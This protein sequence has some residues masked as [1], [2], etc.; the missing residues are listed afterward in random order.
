[1]SNWDKTQPNGREPIS[2]G[3]LRIREIKDALETAFG[4]EHDFPTTSY[5]AF[6]YGNSVTGY[7]G[8]WRY[9]NVLQR[10]ERYTSGA[11]AGIA[12][13]VNTMPSGTK[14]IFFQASAPTGWTQDTSFGNDEFLRV[15]SS[16]SISSGG[17]WGPT[18]ETYAST[19]THTTSSESATLTHTATYQKGTTPANPSYPPTPPPVFPYFQP[20]T[21]PSGHSV[22]HS[23]PTSSSGSHGHTVDSSWRPEYID[24]IVA[25]KD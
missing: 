11:W 6:P 22:T 13:S 7:E 2:R 10:I 9:N 8:R 4:E 24:V 3:A 5:H 1:M 12:L 14:T 25:T 17:S 16:G 19:H 18:V 20:Q 23:H 21:I 15:I